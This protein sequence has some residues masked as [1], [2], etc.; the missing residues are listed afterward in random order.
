MRTLVTLMFVVMTGCAEAP[1][2]EA[3]TH[4]P[5]LSPAST[6]TMTCEKT[7]FLNSDGTPFYSWNYATAGCPCGQI[8]QAQDPDPQPNTVC[9]G[10][11]DVGTTKPGRCTPS[12]LACVPVPVEDT[13]EL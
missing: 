5:L 2:R 13:Q 7:D 1:E 10:A 3:V 12:P 9:A 4:A 6:C 8:C 11:A